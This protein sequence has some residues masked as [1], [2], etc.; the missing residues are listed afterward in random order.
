L[1]EQSVPLEI[2]VVNSGGGDP[3]AVLPQ[4]WDVKIVSVTHLLWP[5]A[6]RNLGIRSSQAPWIA[7]LAADLTAQS[8]WAANRMTLHGQ[9]HRAVA[10]AVVNSHPRNLYAWA[11]HLSVFVR[12]LP[13]ISRRKARL[14]GVSYS[15]AL[16][17]R[18]GE[19]REDLRIGEDTDFHSRFDRSDRPLWAPS[20]QAVHRSPTTFGGMI[21][22]QIARGTREGLHRPPS[23]SRSFLPRIYRRFTSIALLS[24]RSVRGIDRFYVLGCWPL[25]LV[26]ACAYETGVKFGR[27]QRAA[28]ALAVEAAGTGGEA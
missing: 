15:R 28:E 23:D 18:Y 2:V 17:D 13:R 1:R 25:L 14:Y 16:F 6:A 3:Q 20:I 7:F 5:G 9:G 10:S 22:D 8:N 4:E 12:R 11:S 21:A 19:F 24:L 26:C 27:R